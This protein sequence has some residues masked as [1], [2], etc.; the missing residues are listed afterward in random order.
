[1][2]EK[3]RK[4]GNVSFDNV[5]G[6]Y[7]TNDTFFDPIGMFNRL[8]LEQQTSYAFA[9]RFFNVYRERRN[10][11]ESGQLK[12]KKQ[13]LREEVL[14]PCLFRAGLLTLYIFAHLTQFNS[15]LIVTVTGWDS[16]SIQVFL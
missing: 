7:Y 16:A 12:L 10:E 11:P 4:T 5:H 9:G 2:F 1:M 8:F 14:K 13:R 3:L 6:Q 15:C